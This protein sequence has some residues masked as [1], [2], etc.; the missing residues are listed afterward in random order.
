M[1]PFSEVLVD[2]LKQSGEYKALQKDY[3]KLIDI[4]ENTEDIHLLFPLLQ[5]SRIAGS[6]RQKTEKT[7][8]MY[9]T[10]ILN[11]L[12]ENLFR[13]YC[14]CF[15]CSVHMNHGR[16]PLFETS[17]NHWTYPCTDL[18]RIDFS[19]QKIIVYDVREEYEKAE[20]Y[21]LQYK[22][23]KRKQMLEAEEKLKQ[24][25]ENKKNRA[26]ILKEIREQIFG[27]AEVKFFFFSV[28]CYFSPSK[29]KALQKAAEEMIHQQERIVQSLQQKM[30]ELDSRSYKNIHQE[31][32]RLQQQVLDRLT[33][34]GFKQETAT[35]ST[36][37]DTEDE[38]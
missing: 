22:E 24:L 19:E 33:S 27:I 20:E 21:F 38:V 8:K 30:A 9:M 4:I 10:E 13:I 17:P 6:L 18:L 26:F 34:L 15:D 7:I 23:R 25:K 11:G 28:S 36:L 37:L 5:S 16:V 12:D 3:Q 32:L 14:S 31:Y 1:N 29:Y 2:A 35:L